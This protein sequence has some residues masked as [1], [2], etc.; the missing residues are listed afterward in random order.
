M[1]SPDI[2]DDFTIAQ[3]V[4]G[5][6]SGAENAAIERRLRDDGALREQYYFWISKF[7]SLNA[8]YVPQPAPVP[9]AAVARRLFGVPPRRKMSLRLKL[10][11]GL[12]LCAVLAVKIK[13]IVMI[14]HYLSAGG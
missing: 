9:Y 5:L 12:A 14:V 10:A 11:I 13:L 7:E 6:L 3:Y 2:V 8:A 4:M 1:K